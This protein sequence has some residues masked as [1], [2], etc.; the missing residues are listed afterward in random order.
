VLKGRDSARCGGQ[1]GPDVVTENQCQYK[2][3]LFGFLI[4][5]SF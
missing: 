3:V 2:G 4:I 1:W 5:G